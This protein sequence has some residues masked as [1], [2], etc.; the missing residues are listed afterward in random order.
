VLETN[1]FLLSLKSMFYRCQLGKVVC[2]CCPNIV[3]EVSGPLFSL[4]GF[5]S[6]NLG[7][8]DG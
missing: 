3:I 6:C 1:S 7:A 2:Y 5:I 4:L 8:C